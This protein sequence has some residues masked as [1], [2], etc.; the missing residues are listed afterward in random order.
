[1]I[2]R[3]PFCNADHAVSDQMDI[4]AITQC[5]RCKK[6]YSRAESRK[7]KNDQSES[8]QQSD[9]QSTPAPVLAVRENVVS[10]SDIRSVSTNFTA[11]LEKASLSKDEVKKF[12]TFFSELIIGLESIHSD[13]TA[14]TDSASRD[15]SNRHNIAFTYARDFYGRIH[16]V[17]R[18]QTADLCI[19]R[20][21]SSKFNVCPDDSFRF[22]LNLYENGSL[23]HRNILK[24]DS[25]SKIDGRWEIVTAGFLGKTLHQVLQKIKRMDARSATFLGLRI[26]QALAHAASHHIGHH[27]L[28]LH[29]ILIDRSGSV[30]L[31][32]LGLSKVVESCWE[33]LFG[34]SNVSTNW[35]YVNSTHWL[36]PE[37]CR[38]EVNLTSASD[39][40]TMGCMLHRMISGSH[41]VAGTSNEETLQN[42]L[43]KEFEFQKEVQERFPVELQRIIKKMLAKNIANRYTNWDAL[44]YDLERFLKPEQIENDQEIVQVIGQS[45]AA[46]L[47]LGGVRMT[48][49]F[50][51]LGIAGIWLSCSIFFVLT[52]S[53]M[54]IVTNCLMILSLFFSTFFR[55]MQN[56]GEDKAAKFWSMFRQNRQSF[57]FGIAVA[58]ML[59]VTPF[60]VMAPELG[61]F[62]LIFS[63]LFGWLFGS[64]IEKKIRL[65]E[66]PLLSRCMSQIDQL[67]SKKYS[68]FRIEALVWGEIGHSNKQLFGQLF[69]FPSLVTHSRSVLQKSI[70]LAGIA[71]WFY[72][73]CFLFF[74][75]ATDFMTEWFQQSHLS[76]ELHK[77][78]AGRTKKQ[79][80]DEVATQQKASELAFLKKFNEKSVKGINSD[81]R[82]KLTWNQIGESLFG[83]RFRLFIAIGLLIFYASAT[84]IAGVEHKLSED[85]GDIFVFFQKDFR[86][87]A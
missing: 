32:D 81:I 35:G 85:G 10:N 39:I 21:I 49:H 30:R 61:S 50:L 53:K 62:V 44:I 40:Y 73:R 2:I 37:Q 58:S 36:S 3:C 5:P 71:Q 4:A 38:N 22:L 47:T 77:N 7:K 18:K 19:V 46:L 28:S 41:A 51:R 80:S 24:I 82:S 12:V 63:A 84:A 54:L 26:C 25:I 66:E 55:A 15:F 9:T 20:E 52:N 31:L 29:R 75:D 72:F 86:S 13:S 1:M 8:D 83:S 17:K 74:D 65:E 76:K 16:F 70:R 59:L 56:G 48:R 60:L 23:D 11:A 64:F 27:C 33:Q 45:S 43:S 57:S 68:Q 34:N 67:R 14:P 87:G 6:R 79:I 78:R 69:G 42:H